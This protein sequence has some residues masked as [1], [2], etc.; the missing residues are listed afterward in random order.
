MAESV[1]HLQEAINHA[2]ADHADVATK[3]VEEAL[4]HMRKSTDD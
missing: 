4:K 2:K 1:K 3:H